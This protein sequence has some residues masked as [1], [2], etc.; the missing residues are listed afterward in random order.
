MIPGATVL[1]LPTQKLGSNLEHRR[2]ESEQVKKV[3]SQKER[4]LNA[5]LLILSVEC[6]SRVLKS[7]REEL[8]FVF[9]AL[10]TRAVLI[11]DFLIN[12]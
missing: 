5:R 8:L 7:F 2:A 11:L 9:S 4:Q 10:E 1:S 3:A 12:F 6:R